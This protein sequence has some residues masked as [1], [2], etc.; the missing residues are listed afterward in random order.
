MSKGENTVFYNPRKDNWEMMIVIKLFI[1][2]LPSTGCHK[3]CNLLKMRLSS[4]QSA[5]CEPEDEVDSVTNLVKSLLKLT[6]KRR[7][8]N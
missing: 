5:V 1:H 4:L 8:S 7:C 2:K 3:K 6:F